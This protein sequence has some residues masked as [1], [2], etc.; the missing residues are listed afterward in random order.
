VAPLLDDPSML[1]H[2]DQV[3]VTDRREPVGDDER[4]SP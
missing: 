1:E 4:G 2:D 3:G